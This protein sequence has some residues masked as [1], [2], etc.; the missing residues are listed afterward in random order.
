VPIVAC[1]V[2]GVV[3]VVE[4]GVHGR[5]V[6]AGNGRELREALAAL[7]EDGTARSRLGAAGRAHVQR[8]FTIASMIAAHLKVYADA[9]V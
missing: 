8:N 2:G 1:S 9:A 3:D 5:L 7:L 6:A 4:D